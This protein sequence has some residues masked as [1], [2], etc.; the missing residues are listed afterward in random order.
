MK[1]FKI[2]VGEIDWVYAQDMLEALRFYCGETG[3]G[4]DEIESIEEIPEEKWDEIKVKNSDW[5]EDD[6]IEDKEWTFRE[7]VSGETT[8]FIIAST[9]Y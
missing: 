6:P 9:A 8:P 3:L 4:L 7:A 1:I 5:H 2:D